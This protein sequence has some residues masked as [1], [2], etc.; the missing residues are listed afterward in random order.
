MGLCTSRVDCIFII[1]ADRYQ[2]API[3]FL[4]Q[5]ENLLRE[6]RRFFSQLNGKQLII[7]LASSL[8]WNE[9]VFDTNE[10]QEEEEEEEAR[11]QNRPFLKCLQTSINAIDD[12]THSNRRMDGVGQ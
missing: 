4:F 12:G 7:G 1:N 11:Q 10:D 6:S 9:R 8:D 2:I 3:F 5:L